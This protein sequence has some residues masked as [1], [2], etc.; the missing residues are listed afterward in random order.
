MLVIIGTLLPDI[1]LLGSYIGKRLRV[2]SIILL[3]FKHRGL[4]HS[5]TLAIILF[6]IRVPLLIILGFIGHLFLD[7]FSHAGIKIFWPLKYKARFII[8]NSFIFEYIVLSLCILLNI[9]LIII[10]V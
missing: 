4:F 2:F 7:M 10:Q 3:P 9:L 6:F 1:D 8:K 5:L